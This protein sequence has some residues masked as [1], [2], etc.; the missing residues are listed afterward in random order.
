M[1]RLR[2]RTHGADPVPWVEPTRPPGGLCREPAGVS[3]SQVACDPQDPPQRRARAG[4][5]GSQGF[6][7]PAHVKSMSAHA[8]RSLIIAR[9]KLVGQR[10]TLENQIRGLAVVFGVRLPRA[11]TAAFIDKASEQARGSRSLRRHAG[12]DRRAGCC[13]DGGRC[14]RRRHKAHDKGLG[15]LPPAHDDPS[16]GQMTALAFVAAIDD[17]SRIRRSRDARRLSGPRSKTLSIRGGRLRRR[18]LEMRRRAGADAAVRGRQRHADPLQ[19]PAQAEGVGVRDR[20]RSSMRKARI[21]LARRLAI[22]M[23]AMLRDGTE[24]VAA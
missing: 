5:F 16:V 19:R 10:V 13:D 3:G 21:A 24:F 4:A 18:N 20:K 9:K 2:D 7:K 15:S 12:S 6:F 22:I 17:P 1:D 23:H 11:L 14:D 8:V